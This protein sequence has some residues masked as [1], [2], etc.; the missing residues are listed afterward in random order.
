MQIFTVTVTLT[1]LVPD[2]TLFP[3]RAVWIL[4][5]VDSS[6][7]WKHSS[8][9]LVHIFMTAAQSFS[10]FVSCTSLKW[11]SRSTTALHCSAG[12][13]RGDCGGHVT[14]V[15]QSKRD[16]FSLS[17]KIAPTSWH[18]QQPEPFIRG[19]L[20]LCFHAVGTKNRDSSHSE[21]NKEMIQ[22]SENM[23]QP[24]QYNVKFLPGRV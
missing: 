15:R 18:Q 6:K 14:T 7:S 11:M 9:I 3:V 2:W 4:R 24:T 5:G 23:S 1:L 21:T 20:E 19:R 17:I 12:L 16:A 22:C 8:N 13:R 10:R